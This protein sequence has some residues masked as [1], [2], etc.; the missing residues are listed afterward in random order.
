MKEFPL[1]FS[2][3]MVRANRAGLKR[4]TRRVVN[5]ANL[6]VVPRKDVRP[7]FPL[8][9]LPE[10]SNILAPAGEKLKAVLNRNGAVTCLT[11]GGQELGLKPGEFDFLC[12][13][14]Q[15]E[16]VLTAQGGKHTWTIIPHES[17][18]WVRE[19]W[20]KFDSGLCGCGNDRCLCPPDGTP[21]F[22][23]DIT[24][25]LDYDDECGP[26]VPSIHMPR[27]ACRDVYG[28]SKV[29]LERLQAITREDAIDEGV[30]CCVELPEQEKYCSRCG[31][32]NDSGSTGREGCNPITSFRDLW[33][34]L[35]GKK[36]G[37]AWGDNPW[38]WVV[39]YNNP[40]FKRIR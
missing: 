17:R 14:A 34:S 19:T 2:G 30:T 4:M 10:A 12:P 3:L 24:P 23:A 40:L 27:H 5:M 39:E 9:L 13:Y 35:N 33:E 31:A 6:R 16:T 29:R 1:I 26:W 38:V 7:D 11:S 20:R 15:G 37:R 32:C 18:V 22:R 28:V 36:P 25:R 8:N 21:M